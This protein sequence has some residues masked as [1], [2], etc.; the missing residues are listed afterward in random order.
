MRAGQRRLSQIARA[1]YSDPNRA[2][3]PITAVHQ[4]NLMDGVYRNKGEGVASAGSSTVVVVEDARTKL[5]AI[6][7]KLSARI[8]E[9]KD[10]PGKQE[11]TSGKTSP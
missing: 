6:L 10:V 2:G 4:L 5:A 1:C 11:E 8:T 7:N 9:A 3:D